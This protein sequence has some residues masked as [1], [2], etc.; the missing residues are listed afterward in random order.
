MLSS[1]HSGAYDGQ[2]SLV[3][4]HRHSNSLV[5]YYVISSNVNDVYSIQFNNL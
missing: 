5:I 3:Y 4:S 1:N 2:V